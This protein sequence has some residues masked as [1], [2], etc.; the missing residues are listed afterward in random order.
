MTLARRERAGGRLLASS[1]SCWE[2]GLL[3]VAQP[4]NLNP[5]QRDENSPSL[6]TQGRQGE[7]SVLQIAA[8]ARLSGVLLLFISPQ[9]VASARMLAAWRALGARRP[10]VNESLLDEHEHEARS[11]GSAAPHRG[12]QHDFPP[13]P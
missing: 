3:P 5:A 4:L 7:S 10:G 11:S 8:D 12:T 1:N 6:P 9:A 2:T 13:W